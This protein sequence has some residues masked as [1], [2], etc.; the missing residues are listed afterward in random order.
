MLHEECAHR[1]GTEASSQAGCL[2]VCCTW[3]G[4]AR[5]AL[6]GSG[7]GTEM[8]CVGPGVGVVTSL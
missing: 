3:A 8:T 5:A 2:G 1:A 6:M 7:M 4:L